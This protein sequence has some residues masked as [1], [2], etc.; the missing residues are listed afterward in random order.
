MKLFA[1][2]FLLMTTACIA[3][4]VAIT[5]DDL[6]LNGG[7]PPGVTQVEIT[8]ETL[9][10]LKNRRVPPVYGFINAKKLEGNLDA[11]EALHI[12]AA[13]EPFANHTYGHIDLT[14][15]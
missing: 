11:A 3:Q 7:L 6:P 2:F 8:Q 9:A 5:F 12:W 10:V 4:K 1:S 15:N 14:T 13:S